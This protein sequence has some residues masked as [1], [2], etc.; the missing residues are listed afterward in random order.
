V[1]TVVEIPCNFTVFFLI[2]LLLRKISMSKLVESKSDAH[3]Y[4]Y[5]KGKGNVRDAEKY[6]LID[7]Y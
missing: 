5:S 4:M 7:Y 2:P 3:Q 6:L 1:T